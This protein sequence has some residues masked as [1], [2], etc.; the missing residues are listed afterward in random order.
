M[1][2]YPQK[3][4]EIP[5]KQMAVLAMDTICNVIMPHMMIM[6]FMFEH[7]FIVNANECVF[8][9]CARVYIHI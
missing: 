8:T 1:A 3:H 4:L 7:S 2:R 9:L 5:Q 6:T